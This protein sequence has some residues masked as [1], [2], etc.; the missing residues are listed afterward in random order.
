MKWQDKDESSVF[1]WV[2]DF[3]VKKKIKCKGNNKHIKRTNYW[4]TYLKDRPLTFLL[5]EKVKWAVKHMHC[6][7]RKNDGK[8]LS[9][10]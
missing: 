1:N 9:L 10:H 5:K 8:P 2:K 7:S 6:V 4:D 3:T